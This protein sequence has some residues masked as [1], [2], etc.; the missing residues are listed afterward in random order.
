M[1]GEHTN[2][3][4]ER[5]RQARRDAAMTQ[6]TLSNLTGLRQFHIS[7]IENGTIK[8]VMTDTLKALT[9]ALHVSADYLIGNVDKPARYN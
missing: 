4:G 2:K 6:E 3:L 1:L 7:R 9:E 8:E 5:V